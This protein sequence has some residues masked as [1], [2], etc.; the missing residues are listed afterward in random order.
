MTSIHPDVTTD[1][2]LTVQMAERWLLAAKPGARLIYGIGPSASAAA[3]EDVARWF[4]AQAEKGFV[5]LFQRRAGRFRFEYTAVRCRRL[6]N[7]ALPHLTPVAPD[8]ARRPTRL[9]GSP[10]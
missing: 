4:M 1:A 7:D 2:Q 10:E 6:W 8:R 3:G 9:T 5:L